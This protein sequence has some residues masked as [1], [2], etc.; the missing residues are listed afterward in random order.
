[1]LSPRGTSGGRAGEGGVRASP[2]NAASSPRPS[3]PSGEEREKRTP[4]MAK[5]IQG[6]F[7]KLQ[8]LFLR[9]FGGPVRGRSGKHGERLRRPV[10]RQFKTELRKVGAL[11]PEGQSDQLN[12]GKAEVRF[13][14]QGPFGG[15]VGGDFR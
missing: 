5:H 13:S 4:R 9:R 14:H 6:L 1:S 7:V 15:R 2:S 11:Q 3:P 12:A 8:V 10:A